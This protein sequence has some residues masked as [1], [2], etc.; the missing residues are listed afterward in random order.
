MPAFG[1]SQTTLAATVRPTQ[2]ERDQVRPANARDEEARE[3]R[4]DVDER[5]AEVG[6]PEDEQD[7]H[8]PEPD[9]LQHDARPVQPSHAVD[10][11]AGEGEDEE[12][13][14]ELRRLELERPEVDP[15]PRAARLLRERIHEQHEHD[16]G[17]VERQLEAAVAIRVDRE[18]DQHPGEADPRGDQLARHVVALVARRRRSA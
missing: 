11:E 9:R 18:R 17:R 12:E 8:E 5:G 3:E 2:Q 14:P 6:L 16:R 7:R 15:A 4:G 13:L 10:E 1:R